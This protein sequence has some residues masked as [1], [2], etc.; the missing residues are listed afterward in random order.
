MSRTHHGACHFSRL[1][2]THDRLDGVHRTH[3]IAMD[4]TGQGETLAGPDPL[5][6]DHRDI[7]IL[8]RGHLNTLEIKQVFAAGLQ[9]V[10]IE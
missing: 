9:V 10:G 1:E 3:F 6:H 5:G 7:P 8:P 2:A 4:T